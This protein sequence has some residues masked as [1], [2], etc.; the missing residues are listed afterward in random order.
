MIGS[1]VFFKKDNSFIS[2]VV[3]KLTHSEFTHVAL[4]VGYDEATKVAT[5][6]ESDKFVN[7]RITTVKIDDSHVVYSTDNMTK[8][9][10]DKVVKYSYRQLGVKYD[11]FQIL[12]LFISLT[13]KGDRYALFNSTNKYICS[14][15]IDRAYL[16]AGIPRLNNLNI[17]NITPQ[18]LIEVYRLKRI[19]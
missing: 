11:Y 18:E 4:I 7:T 1:V 13:I 5:V 17:G 10:S 8:E 6:I 2:R 12:G 15:L 16:N 9:V 14:E 19:E 3:A